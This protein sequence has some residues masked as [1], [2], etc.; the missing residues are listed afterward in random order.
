MHA[1]R[2]VTFLLG[3]W[4]FCTLGV[5][6][7]AYF[8]L[9]L[10]AGVMANPAPPVKKDHQ[11]LRARASGLAAAAFRGGGQPVLFLTLGEGGNRPGPGADP[12]GV[13]SRRQITKAGS[14]YFG[15]SLMLL[16]ALFQYNALSPEIAYRGREVDFPPRQGER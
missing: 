15:T 14:F 4:I 6:V 1:T 10:P 12:A 9:R 13:F 16:L 3:G 2:I 8:N 11:G 5:D 7:A